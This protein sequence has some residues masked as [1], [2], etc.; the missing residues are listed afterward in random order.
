MSQAVRALICGIFREEFGA[1]PSELTAGISPLFFNSMLHMRPLDLDRLLEGSVGKHGSGQPEL[2]VYGDCSPH[3]DQLCG[4]AWCQRTQGVNCC[5]IMLG[6]VR[7][8]ELRRQGSFFLMPEWLERWQE[9]FKHE[10]GLADSALARQFMAE[11]MSRFVYIDTGL[12]SLPQAALD[13]I[14]TY[15]GLP[16]TIERPGLAHLET[17]IREGLAALESSAACGPVCPCGR[18]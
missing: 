11:S 13:E 3:I 6:S 16:L 15:F 2:L 12:K 1:L 7:Y 5:E 8:R 14:A 9:V 4:S 17:A 10:L 18:L